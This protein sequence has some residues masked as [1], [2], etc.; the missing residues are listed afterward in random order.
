MTSLYGTRFLL[1]LK[2]PE[3]RL[4]LT[5]FLLRIQ[6][7]GDSHKWG[8]PG[9]AIEPGEA[10]EMTAVREAKEETGLDVSIGKLIGFYTDPDIIYPNGDQAQSI[11]KR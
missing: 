9:G 4:W 8:F 2:L 5:G 3:R 6:R 1:S 7:R 11:K 10:P